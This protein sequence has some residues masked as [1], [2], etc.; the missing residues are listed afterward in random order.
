MSFLVALVEGIIVLT[1]WVLAIVCVAMILAFLLV[2]LILAI[3]FL[4]GEAFCNALRG[5]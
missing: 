4:S 2:L 5:R 1:S 3:L